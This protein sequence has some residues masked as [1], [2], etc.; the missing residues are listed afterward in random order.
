MIL[1]CLA[2]TMTVFNNLAESECLVGSICRVF[3]VTLNPRN[4]DC[5]RKGAD[6]LWV[7]HPFTKGEAV[8]LTSEGLAIT[9][10][11]LPAKTPEKLILK[12]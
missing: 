9:A 10:K 5:Y 12:R 6:G 7:L 1:K 8:I 4:T 11:Q 2:A 3:M